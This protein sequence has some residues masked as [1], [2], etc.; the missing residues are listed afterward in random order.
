MDEK[1]RK[2][3]HDTIRHKQLVLESGKILSD[4]LMAQGEFELSLALLKRCATHDDSKFDYEEI[5]SF[6]CIPDNNG[7]KDPNVKMDDFMKKAIQLHWKNNSHHPEHHADI[8]D[9]S[10]LDLLE[11]ACDC[12]SRS[13]EFG[14]NLL[15]FIDIRQTTRF[16]MPVELYE[17]YRFFCSVLVQEGEKEKSKIKIIKKDI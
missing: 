6:V 1:I 10:L 3:I 7:M 13:L 11:M 5:M 4:Y 14:T 17:K 12:Y 8:M 15:E 9:M 2:F 16:Q